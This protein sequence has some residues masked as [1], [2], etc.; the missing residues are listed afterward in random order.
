MLEIVKDSFVQ[1]TYGSVAAV[2]YLDGDSFM[3]AQKTTFL[4]VLSLNAAL[5]EGTGVIVASHASGISIDQCVFQNCDNT[6]IYASDTHVAVS[7]S[8]FK[9]GRRSSYLSVHY[10]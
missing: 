5:L 8:V 10:S 2:A 9:F 1:H 7:N 6:N 3:L 4:D